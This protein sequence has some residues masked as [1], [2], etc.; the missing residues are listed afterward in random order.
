MSDESLILR[1]IEKISHHIE[2][3]NGELGAIDSRVAVL[4]SQ[5]ADVLWLQR[6]LL[7][8][9]V[10]AVVGA[11]LALILKQKSNSRK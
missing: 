9:V 3:I 11:V 6:L 7:G 5:V 8:T 2:V 4:E 10:I 1:Y